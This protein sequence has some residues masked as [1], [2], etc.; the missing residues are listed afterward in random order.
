MRNLVLSCRALG[1]LFTS[2]ASQFHQLFFSYGTVV[3]VGVGMTRDC[4]TLMVAQYFKRK[5]E[6]VEIF[7]VSGSGL[8]IVVM[9]TFIKSAIE[10]VG[11]RCDWQLFDP[12]QTINFL[13]FF[14]RLG[15]QCVTICVFSTFILGTCYRSASLYHPQRRAILHL[16]NQKRKIKDKSKQFDGPPFFDFSTLKS[17]TVRILMLSTAIT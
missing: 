14:L 2:F 11:W 5:R 10:A 9:S 3:G 12:L 7:I 6:F 16:K 15:L 17:K 13:D 1:C 8:G 4:S